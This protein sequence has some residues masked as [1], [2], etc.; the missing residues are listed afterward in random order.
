MHEMMG[1]GM[2][3]MGRTAPIAADDD[4]VHVLFAGHIL[5][6]TRDLEQLRTKSLHGGDAPD[7]GEPAMAPERAAGRA[8][9]SDDLLPR[10]RWQEGTASGV[11]LL[12]LYVVLALVPVGLALAFEPRTGESFLNELGKGAGMLGFALLALQVALSA[13]LRLLDAP[14][15]LDVVMQFH[16][17]MAILAGALLLS[18]PFLLA[19]GEDRWYLFTPGAGWQVNLGQTGLLILILIILC[20]LFFGK[21]GIQYQVWR[22]SHKAAVAVVVIGFAHSLFIGPDLQRLGIRLYWL[23]LLGM[24][25]GLFLF[26][27]VFV[28]LW[29]RRRFK[30]VSVERET[31][32]TFTVSLEPQDGRPLPHSPGQFMWLK[33]RR[34]GRPS[35]EHP[36]T[37]SSSPTREPPLTATIKES[38]DFTN[39]IGLTRPGDTAGVEAPYGRFSFVHHEPKAFLFIAGGVGITPILSMLRYLKDAGNRRQAVLIYGNKTEADIIR[40]AELDD[41]P[42]NVKV[43]HVL[44][45]AGTEWQGLKGYITQDVIQ[46]QAG[47]VLAEADVYVCGPP[48]MMDIVVSSVR[49]LGVPDRRIHYE[50]FAI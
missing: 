23:A 19:L 17:G 37:I 8:P 48:P 10:H 9:R 31:H 1:E 14:F 27:N 49:G 33:L 2:P 4:G 43:V 18:H 15:G 30:V 32:D 40:R 16:K 50:R 24:A 7:K 22:H 45:R 47:E 29:G 20:A 21:L 34:P 25:V 3:M 12:V 42:G 5:V 6:Y 26:R 39:T 11:C 38:G 44:S 41:M 46:R 35:E 13:R 28:P 36:F